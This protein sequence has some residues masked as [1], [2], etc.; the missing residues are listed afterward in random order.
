MTNQEDIS[1]Y[2]GL[3]KDTL[4][5]TCAKVRKNLQDLFP[6]IMILLLVLRK[7]NFTQMAKYGKHNEHTYRSAFRKGIDWCVYNT[8][9]I[10]E[11]FDTEN[12]LLAVAIDQSYIRKAGK[13]TY[14]IGNYWSGCAQAVKHGCEITLLAIVNAT[15]KDAMAFRAIQTP[16]KADGRKMSLTDFYIK[17]VKKYPKRMQR[18]THNM[19]GDAAFSTKHFTDSMVELG[20]TFVSR[21]RKDTAVRYLYA[22]KKTGKRGRPKTFDG[23][24]DFESP[25]LGRMQ[26]IDSLSVD[27]GEYY[28]IVA[29]VKCLKQNVRL[30]VWCLKGLARV[31][32]GG[33]RLYYSTD[34]DMSGEDTMAI[35]HSRFQEEYLFRDGKQFTGLQDCQARSKKKLHFAAINT[36]KVAMARDDKYKSMSLAAYSMLMHNMFIYQRIIDV[37]GI[38]LDKEKNNL[39]L[40]DF[41]SLSEAAA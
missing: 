19:V 6:E 38:K 33:F 24:I 41:R 18:I 26:K 9:L 7:K 34:K 16:G 2:M 14:G 1:H 27:D 36:A 10:R 29:N 20:F 40:K 21:L 25:D 5:A 8:K 22:G 23:D 32:N 31:K 4:L 39:I 15:Q 12:D 37:S 28:T 17:Q 13:K 30:V 11:L 3:A 35:Y